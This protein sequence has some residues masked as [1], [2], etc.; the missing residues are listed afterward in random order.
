[1]KNR[2]L[3]SAFFALLGI[4]AAT[5]GVYLSISFR[6]AD[7]ILVRSADKAE[8]QVY[9]FL[10]AVKAND[11][12]R[13]SRMLY[14]QP[15]LA[16]SRLPAE[17]VGVLIWA[18]FWDSFTY[19]LDGEFYATEDGIARR[20]S[21]SMLDIDALSDD[22]QKRAQTFFQERVANTLDANEVYDQNHEYRMDFVMAVLS[23]ATKTALEKNTVK[24]T[25]WITVKMVYE[26]GQWWILPEERLL[27]VIVGGLS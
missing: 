16:A 21:L 11:F 8:S 12:D 14:G 22:L 25:E 7:P 6:T 5:A 26:D 18:A 3:F 2:K 19:E 4:C 24:K 27:A 1:M 17:N 13:A 15:D 20:V 9:D 10:N 23:D